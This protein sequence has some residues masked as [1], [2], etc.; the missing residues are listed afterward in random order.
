M[1]VHF[2]RTRP[3]TVVEGD[4]QIQVHHQQQR[5]IAL[6]F[7]SIS[8]DQLKEFVPLVFAD[9]V[10]DVNNWMA[11]TVDSLGQKR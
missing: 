4:A 1:I 8:S 9:R 5:M 2:L 6:P 10:E 11:R 7:S 3:K